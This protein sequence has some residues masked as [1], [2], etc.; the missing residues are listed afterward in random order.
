VGI[1]LD[2]F[3]VRTIMVPAIIE[4]VGDR[5][6]WPSTASGGGHTMHETEQDRV[7]A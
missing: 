7:T 3:V 1:L 5:A 2:T 6:W 4:L